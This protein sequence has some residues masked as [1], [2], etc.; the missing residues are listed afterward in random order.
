MD[1]ASKLAE[2]EPAQRAK[3]TETTTAEPLKDTK[4]AKMNKL[5][6]RRRLTVHVAMSNEDKRSF[7]AR[8]LRLLTEHNPAY[9]YQPL[10]HH[11]EGSGWHLQAAEDEEK[12]RRSFRMSE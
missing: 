11:A 9:H 6:F 8:N 7:A 5:G 12:E 4:T 10:V 3:L 1:A 2:N